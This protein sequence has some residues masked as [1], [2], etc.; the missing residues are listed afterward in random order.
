MEFD[1]R[2]SFEF[3]FGSGH[4]AAAIKCL[5]R[6]G[7]NQENHKVEVPAS[8]TGVHPAHFGLGYIFGYLTVIARFE[9]A[10]KSQ[11]P[12]PSSSA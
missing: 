5:S 3:G 2:Q 4:E 8:V 10:S 12:I 11:N 1:K 9:Q 7:H 6:P